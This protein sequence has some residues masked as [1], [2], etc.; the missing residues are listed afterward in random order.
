MVIAASHSSALVSAYLVSRR[1]GSTSSQVVN[2][3]HDWLS[4]A[5]VEGAVD[6]I[7]IGRQCA[8]N[9][10]ARL[11]NHVFSGGGMSD[12]L[13]AIDYRPRL[14]QRRD[15]GIGLV[16]AG[17][18]VQYGHLPAYKQAGFNVVGITDLNLDRAHRVAAEHGIPRVFD[19]LDALIEDDAIEIVDIAVYPWEQLSIIERVC[20]AKRHSLC[21]KPLSDRYEDAVRAV[22]VAHA[23][24]VKLAVNQQMRWDAGI[25]YSK[26]LIEQGWIGTPTYASIQV[27]TQTDWSLWPWIYD[28]ERIEV[29][30][31]SIHYLDSL[32]Y[33]LGD[34]ERVFVSGSRS[35]GETT[36]AE[37]RTITIW[38]YPAEL[39]AL[40]D[41]SHGTWHDD[42]YATFRIEGTEGVVKG[43]IGLL[44]DYPKGRP[45]TI[46]F[47][48]AKHYPRTWIRP[49]LESL[50]IP[51]A[52]AGPMASLMCSIE[53]GGA[54]E[55]NG[56]DNL[57]TLQ[58]VFAAYRS[59]AEGRAVALAEISEGH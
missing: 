25:R 51:D 39:R 44:Y 57:I 20:V 47:W 59:M 19:D 24:D 42:R 41:V 46:E 27:H 48:S 45:D 22:N 23:A 49:T 4:V 53:E 10:F 34:P 13:A 21:Q 52:F 37:T 54:P 8:I 32:R 18:I 55:T 2:P 35:P 16:G 28:G 33:L 31:H 17:G 38:E 1:P 5:Q 56:A 36:H 12:L 14:P 29:L 7:L 40:I 26:V 11:P 58:A 30:F 15:R 6:M 3:S 9:L 50:W 43:T